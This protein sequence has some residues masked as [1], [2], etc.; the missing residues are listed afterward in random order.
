MLREGRSIMCSENHGQCRNAESL[1]KSISA[2]GNEET[3][4]AAIDYYCN[5]TGDDK[6]Y[7]LLIFNNLK[8]ETR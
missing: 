3:I 4:N 2:L 1:F 5:S 6:N 8:Y 7:I